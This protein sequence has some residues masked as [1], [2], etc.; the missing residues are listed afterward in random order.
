[1]DF[2]VII[3]GAGPFGLSGAAYLKDKGLGVGLFGDPMSFWRDH[4]PAGMYLRSNWEASHISDPHRRL[5]LDH[6]QADMGAQFKQPI[7]L[8]RFIE[9]G[10]WYQQKA[11]PDLVPRQVCELAK[12]G[13]GFTVKLSDGNTAKSKRVIVATGIAHFPWM[14]KEFEGLPPSHVTHSSDHCDLSRFRGRDM[15]VIGGGQSALDAARILHTYDA[16]VEVV[17]R[18]QQIRWVGENAWLHH[19]GFLSWCLYSKLDVGP[20]GISRLV[21]FP[22]L[23]RRLPRRWQDRISLRSIRPAGTGWQRP[24]LAKVSM[25]TDCYATSVEIQGDR[26]S[27]KLN[28]GSER[29]VDHVIVGTGYRVDVRRYKFFNPGIQNS[30]KTV[31]GSPVLARGFESS[32]PGLHFVGKPAGWSFGPVLNFISGSHFAGAELARAIRR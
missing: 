23:F 29:L 4:M 13:N 24:Q 15:L 14:P 32:V 17:A 26:V 16:K 2:D 18:Q 7:P 19:L 5:T 31:S 30:L 25:T 8:E 21:G 9:Y 20:A 12:N 3:I 10:Q 27:V 11:V 28:D 22:N 1:M 6:F